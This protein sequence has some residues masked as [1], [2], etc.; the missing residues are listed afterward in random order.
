MIV[1]RIHLRQRGNHR[2]QH[3]ECQD[4]VARCMYCVLRVIQY[5]TQAWQYKNWDPDQAVKDYYERIKGH[6]K[7]YQ[8]IEEKTWPFIKIINVCSKFS[9]L[10]LDDNDSCRLERKSY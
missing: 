10:P 5:L 2:K 8:T 4:F 6:E 1:C 9:C 7:Y 3:P